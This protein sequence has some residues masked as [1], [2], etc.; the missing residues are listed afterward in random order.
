[1]SEVGPE[2]LHFKQTLRWHWCCWSMDHS[3]RSKTLSHFRNKPKNCHSGIKALLV[4]LT[5]YWRSWLDT[6]LQWTPTLPSPP[7]AKLRIAVPAEQGIL[8]YPVEQQEKI[9]TIDLRL[10]WACQIRT[11][12]ICCISP[13]GLSHVIGTTYSLRKNITF[14]LIYNLLWAWVPLR[15]FQNSK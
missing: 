10:G 3:F 15:N 8:S 2:I 6:R 7:S 13:D 11:Y 5:Q 9:D 4:M 14:P 12:L 1:M